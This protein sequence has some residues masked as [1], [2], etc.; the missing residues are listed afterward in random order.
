MIEIA[1][2][3]RQRRSPAYP[4]IVLS[5]TLE[6]LFNLAARVTLLPRCGTKVE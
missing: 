3:C 1:S 2:V 4:A 6:Q 5:T